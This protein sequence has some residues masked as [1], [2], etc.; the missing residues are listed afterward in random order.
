VGAVLSTTITKTGDHGLGSILTHPAPVRGL[1]LLPTPSAQ[2]HPVH[3]AHSVPQAPMG[4]GRSRECR[5]AGGVGVAFR[6]VRSAFVCCV[7][8]PCV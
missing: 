5:A 8:R 2:S 1:R 6:R 7:W 3:P 4:G